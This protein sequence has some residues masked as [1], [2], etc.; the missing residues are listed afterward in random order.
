MILSEFFTMNFRGSAI[1][2]GFN[3][4]QGVKLDSN[5]EENLS[6]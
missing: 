1:K 5:T 2:E 4:K 3:H 6:L